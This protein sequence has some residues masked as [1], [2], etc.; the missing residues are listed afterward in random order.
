[1][2]EITKSFGKRTLFSSINCRVNSGECLVITGANGTGKTTLI[3]II[4]CL[5]KPSSGHIVISA[6][7][8]LLEDAE[9]V[10]P[11]IGLASPEI[12]FYTQ[13]TAAENISLLAQM[14]DVALS[15]EAIGQSLA[16]VGLDAENNRQIKTY[17]TGMKQRLKF[18]LL[19]AVDPPLWLI[20]EGLSNLDNDGRVQILSLIE[21]ALFRQ[22]LLV[23]ATNEQADVVY[24]SQTIAL[25]RH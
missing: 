10:L 22:R 8:T 2:D 6:G 13:L 1:M 7:Q 15:A 3:K 18:A 25:S 19:K 16:A 17:S 4:A 21:E 14:R 20:D 24:A 23:L 11:Y 9:Q 12:V 5:I